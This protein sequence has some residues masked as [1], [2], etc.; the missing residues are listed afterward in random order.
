MIATLD[1]KCD[2]DYSNSRFLYHWFND[3]DKKRSTK[4][5]LVRA[6]DTLEVIVSP[7]R[8]I[9]EP[10]DDDIAYLRI[11]PNKIVDMQYWNDADLQSEKIGNGIEH[12]L[13]S[14]E[15]EQIV[16][17]Y[18]S[19]KPVVLE[20]S[21]FLMEL[22]RDYQMANYEFDQTIRQKLKMKSIGVHED[23][24]ELDLAE[25]SIEL[26]EISDC[27]AEIIQARF[28]GVEHNPSR[29]SWFRLKKVYNQYKTI[30]DCLPLE[31]ITKVVSRNIK[32]NAYLP[33]KRAIMNSGFPAAAESVENKCREYAADAY[34]TASKCSNSIS[35]FA[36]AGAAACL[37]LIK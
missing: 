22:V 15:S 13:I 28:M 23:N 20:A 27:L 32:W 25:A 11:H 18:K 36:L 26:N 33:L 16:V 37:S 4:L 7:L 24:E 6:I 30:D 2:I 9:S 3:G 10:F 1:R 12:Y 31:P 34:I 5:T 8:L 14:T 35:D 19:N 21:P 17:P 29:V